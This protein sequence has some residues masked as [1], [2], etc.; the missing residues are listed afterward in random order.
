VLWIAA[1]AGLAGLLTLIPL[2]THSDENKGVAFLPSPIDVLTNDSSK[3]QIKEAINFVA[4]KYGLNSKGLYG[5]IQ[6][7]SSLNPYAVGDSGKARN[8]A[9][10]HKPTFNHFCKGEYDNAKDQL[11]C[12]AQMLK[13]GLGS[14]WTCLWAYETTQNK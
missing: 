6:C 4:N 8:L 13:D 12:L 10:F 7:E 14:H 1:V 11:I 9:Q 5:L 3:E 2:T